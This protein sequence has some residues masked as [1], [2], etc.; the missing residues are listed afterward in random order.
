MS[1]KKI[2][3]LLLSLL[4]SCSLS[5]QEEKH[6]DPAFDAILALNYCQM[7]LYK[8]TEY[9]DR[10][11][12]DEEYNNII[13]NINL[14]KIQDPELIT[15]LKDLLDVLTKFKLNEKDGEILEG[16]Y[17]RKVKGALYS[18][19][20]PSTAAGAFGGAPGP[21]G[22]CLALGQIGCQY[23]SYQNAVSEY[24]EELDEDLW[25]LEKDA[26]I[27]LNEINKTFI[28]V[29]WA[30]LQKYDADD[31]ERLTLSQFEKFFDVLK[32]EDLEQKLR[33]LVRLE[34]EL[35]N[36]P[37]YW[38][39]RGITAS[40]LD[41][42]EEFLKCYT[43]FSDLQN[44]FF[45]EDTQASSLAMIKITQGDYSK[46]RSDLFELLEIVQNED[47]SD[48]R[49]RLF[50][51]LQALNHEEFEM[52][53]ELVLTNLDLE[54]GVEPSRLILAEILA[55][56]GDTAELTKLVEKLLKDV[57]ASSQEVIHMVGF[58]SD[59]KVRQKLRDQLLEIKF[60]IREK[61]FGKDSVLVTLPVRW[62]DDELQ[63]IGELSV[64]GS[65][66]IMAEPEI[67]SN[68]EGYLLE[69]EDV[70]EHSEL[71]EKMENRVLEFRLETIR[72]DVFLMADLITKEVSTEKG[73]LDKGV[74]LATEWKSKLGKDDGGTEKDVAST[75]KTVVSE[76][77]LKSVT[78]LDLEI[79]ILDQGEL[80]FTRLRN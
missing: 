17:E 33:N 11:I 16:V 9:N 62:V 76:F 1:F 44:D 8:I 31:D 49:K 28:D 42:P 36:F 15:V 32:G 4:L 78:Y 10:V 37:P 20:N 68:G 60:E 22:A 18:A 12:L 74:D 5:G 7:S 43:A 24:R 65:D 13:N 45:R 51:S 75:K 14:A 29:S 59:P 19:L 25:Q 64:D 2:C 3:S 48:W 6:Y 53:R 67:D 66:P 55:K 54:I 52:A 80:K 34:S 30:L 23:A 21:V 70:F 77:A 79:E 41:N 39:H 47:R 58:V 40:N 61:R 46:N 56:R 50:C 63:A 69:F 71:L 38:F 73:Y 27:E 35:V 72:N 26:I 57:S